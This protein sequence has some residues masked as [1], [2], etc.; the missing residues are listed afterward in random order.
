M[1]LEFRKGEPR[2]IEAGRMFAHHHE[3]D[4]VGLRVLL[5]LN[6]RRFDRALARVARLLNVIE[7]RVDQSDPVIEILRRRFR[8][9]L[10][11]FAP[12]VRLDPILALFSYVGRIA[13][14]WQLDPLNL[15]IAIVT[16]IDLLGFAGFPI[17]MRV[18]DEM[19]L[20]RDFSRIFQI[21]GE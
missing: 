5:V 13:G 20:R 4:F 8:R 19:M 12:V 21:I 15:G 9:R 16:K 3:P 17:E 1:V 18:H 14:R 6:Q 7:R 10:S 2:I 11:C